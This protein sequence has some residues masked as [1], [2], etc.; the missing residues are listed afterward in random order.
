MRL[1]AYLLITLVLVVCSCTIEKRA[2]RKGYYISWNKSGLKEKNESKEQIKTKDPEELAQATASKDSLRV[3]ETNDT[4]EDLVVENPEKSD[5]LQNNEKLLSEEPEV[6]NNTTVY[7]EK[8]LIERLTE[9]VEK[10]VQTNDD[11]I[12]EN[13]KPRKRLNLFALNA[14]VLAAAYIVLIF[15]ELDATTFII[16]P[17][18]LA[19]ICLFAAIALAVVAIV[20]WKRNPGKFWGTF[21]ALMALILLALGIFLLLL[22]FLVGMG[23]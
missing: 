17:I 1:F 13:E 6:N 16:T 3:E 7:S 4:K 21:F 2:F 14:F 20:K 15:V 5:T 18:V 12:T 10:S 23:L 22:A 19:A 11:P 8:A 9:A